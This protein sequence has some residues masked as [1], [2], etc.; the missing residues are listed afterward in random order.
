VGRWAAEALAATTARCGTVVAT[1]PGIDTG[2][3]A[4]LAALARAAEHEPNLV[5]VEALGRDYPRVLAS[6][7]V[8]VGNSSSGVIEAASVGVP[9][10]DV[11]DRQRGRLRGANVVA[12]GEGRDE[13][14]RGLELA[15]DPAFVAAAREV[16]NPYGAGDA[17]AR[18]ADRVRS[19]PALPRAKPFVDIPEGTR[20]Q[21]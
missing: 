1:H 8:V 11:G 4:V 12:V 9:A 15:L 13:V 14:A 3:E 18:V 16:V 17:A 5:V 19:A 7:D 10:V 20:D 2:R 21:P 6:V